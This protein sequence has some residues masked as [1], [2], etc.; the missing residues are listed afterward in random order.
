MSV[1]NKSI[2]PGKMGLHYMWFLIIFPIA[3]T[4]VALTTS[5]RWPCGIASGWIPTTTEP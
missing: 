2:N 5:R 1:T 3:I 4:G